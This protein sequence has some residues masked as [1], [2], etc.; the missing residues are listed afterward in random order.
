MPLTI[1]NAQFNQFVQFAEQQMQAGKS[2][3]VARVGD[4]QTGPLAGRTITP[5][6]GDWVGIGVGRLRSLKDAN[7]VAR[8]LFKS[9]IADLFGG[10]DKIPD[11]VK[12]AM[13]MADFG[14][15]KPLT[16][17]R[18][19]AVKTAVE[20]IAEKAQTSIEE[21]KAKFKGKRAPQAHALLE[22]AFHACGRNPDAMDIVK[23]NISKL[24][25]TGGSDI[26]TAEQVQK[27]VGDLVA[28]LDELKAVSKDNPGIYAA[29]RQMLKDLGKGLPAGT[30][31]KLVKAVGDIPM[32]DLRRLSGS[33]SGKSIHRAVMQFCKSLNAAMASSGADKLLEGDVYDVMCARTFMTAA[34]LSGCGKGALGKIGAAL[35][36]DTA[37]NLVG[38]YAKCVSDDN[39]YA[40]NE[41]EDVRKGLN[42]VGTIGE[43]YL[44]MLNQGVNF[45]LQR[46]NPAAEQRSLPVDVDV[47]LDAIGGDRFVE[48][49]VSSAKDINAANVRN[50]VDQTVM[51]GG[52]GAEVMKDILHH[53]LAGA[54]EPMEKL[55][56]SLSANANAM[57]NWNICG[58]MKKLA[59]GDGA[60]SQF[61]KDIYRGTNATLTDGKTTIKLTQNFETARD[62]LAQFVT[63]DPKATYKGLAEAANKVAETAAD[64]AAVQ[65]A[66]SDRNKVHLLMA[67]ISQETEKATENGAEYALD[68]RE[69]DS[70]FSISGFKEKDKQAA[71]TY[72]IQMTD[73]GGIAMHYVMDKPIADIDDGNTEGD[74]YEVGEGSKFVCKLDYTLDG[75]EVNR[76]AELDY[77]KFDDREGYQIFN[78]KIDMP[79]GTRQ[80]REHK[81]EKVVDAFPQEF[82]V[83]ADCRMDFTL[84]LNPTE[85]EKIAAQRDE[86][87]I[88]A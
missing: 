22:P 88:V 10:E 65:K 58:E 70:A 26:R 16:A 60:S 54:H 56:K 34:A 53:K 13:K 38:F 77:G 4:A 68:T 7:N 39:P 3:A 23:E 63:G 72:T 46:L 9:A 62:E 55:G 1:N 30:F 2:K 42:D 27:K 18:I 87:P 5:A 43:N 71:R 35:N 86:G 66:A 73:D 78:R 8:D 67:I 20:Q 50:L 15:G 21:C 45:N 47:D 40:Q 64:K 83:K 12:D 81:L 69:A 32:G 19:L 17:R 84:T 11:S 51:G 36:S 33:S 52:K 49:A 80:F 41:S 25:Y 6:K 57:M 14:K 31:A 74:G 61:A 85:E 48:E 76:L 75:K 37:R 29:G 28:S 44:R 82:K 24:V 79:D 59:T